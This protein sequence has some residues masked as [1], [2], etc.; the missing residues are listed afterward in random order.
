VQPFCP[1][2][3]LGATARSAPKL[4]AV[5]TDRTDLSRP[6][7]H[8]GAG[9]VRLCGGKRQRVGVGRARRHHISKALPCC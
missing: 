6:Y 9:Y 2:F 3:T 5:S 1:G 4:R 7:D 8:M